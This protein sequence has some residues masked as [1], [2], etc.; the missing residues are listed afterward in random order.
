M[1]LWEVEGA[2]DVEVLFQKPSSKERVFL[3]LLDSSAV[4]GRWTCR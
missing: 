2:I 4:P 1:L 3:V